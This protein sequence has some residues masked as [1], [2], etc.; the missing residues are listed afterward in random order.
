MS[1]SRFRPGGPIGPAPRVVVN[2]DDF[3]LLTSTEAARALG[4]R[5][6]ELD[7]VP[8]VAGPT[9]TRRYRADIVD[10]IAYRDR[11]GLTPNVRRAP[12]SAFDNSARALGYVL[13]AAIVVVAGFATWLV[14]R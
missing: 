14:I 10:W 13:V 7:D 9:G 11:T 3:P 4:R 12:E 6:A 2:L 1:G 5:I 8:S